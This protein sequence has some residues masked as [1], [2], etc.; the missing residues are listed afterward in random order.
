M[1]MYN[2]KE[3]EEKFDWKLF[4]THLFVGIIWTVICLL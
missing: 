1:K 2:E 4:I 3:T